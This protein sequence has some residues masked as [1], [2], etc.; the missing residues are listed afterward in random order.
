MLPSLLL[1]RPVASAPAHAVT[2]NTRPAWTALLDRCYE[3]AGYAAP[4]VER[5]RPE[6]V[7]EPYNSLLVHSSDMTPTLERFY[8]QPPGLKVLGR[9]QQGETY[10]RE[11]LLT[12]PALGRAV[13]HGVI[14]I[15]LN[16][17]PPVARRRVLEEQ[18]PLGSIL[19]SEGIPHIGWPHDFFRLEAN[20]YECALLDVPE[21][22]LLYGRRNVLLEGSR[23]LLAEV[24]EVLAPAEN[25][26]PQFR[27]SY[28]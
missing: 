16:Q 25:P 15:C 3:S 27:R 13:L 2:G 28:L 18:D 21:T 11:V 9:E 24:I 26:A 14:R 22:G 1:S 7:P 5:L 8:G 23:H 4:Q 20:A 6:Q 10:Y 19:L 17:F 12:M